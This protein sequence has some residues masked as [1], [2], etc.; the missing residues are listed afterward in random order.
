MTTGSWSSNSRSCAASTA[1]AG[2]G[3]AADTGA[4]YIVPPGSPTNAMEEVKAVRAPRRRPKPGSIREPG[5]AERTAQRYPE[6]AALRLPQHIHRTAG[7]H[8]SLEGARCS[9]ATSRSRCKSATWL[10]LSPLVFFNA[11]RT[12]GEA[13]GLI[14]MMGW[15]KQF[16][17]AGAGASS[18]RSGPSVQL[19]EDI[20]RRVLPRPGLRGLTARGSVATGEAGHLRALATPPGWHT[21]STATRRQSLVGRPDFR[22]SMVATVALMH[23]ISQLAWA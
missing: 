10:R 1:R 11:C 3:L 5:L 19:G 7:S 18:G 15:A 8:I 9:L 13:P 22:P 14:Q 21:P 6:R 4:A 20:R 16:M 2:P 17:G 12:A 23:S